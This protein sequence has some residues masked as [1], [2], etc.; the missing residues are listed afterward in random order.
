MLRLIVL[1][2][3][4]LFFSGCSY[5]LHKRQI[6]VPLGNQVVNI[7]HEDYGPGK[8]FV[9]LHANETTALKAAR[10]VAHQLGGQVIT[11]EH[12]KTRDIAFDYHGRHYEFDPNR[13]YTHRGIILTLQQHHCYHPEVVPII[14]QFGKKILAS[15]PSSQVVAV[16]NNQEYSLLDYLPHHSL[17]KDAS[18]LCYNPKVYFRNFFLV[19]HPLDFKHYCSLGYNVVLQASNA[20]NDGSLSIAFKNKS[21]VNVEAGFSQFHSQIQMLKNA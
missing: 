14:E 3:T 13:I 15:I 8:V 1:V 19:T 18:H 10:K 5:Y 7:V 16:H 17:E 2:V 4:V 6:P 21:Y 11:L 12:A 20:A 9:H